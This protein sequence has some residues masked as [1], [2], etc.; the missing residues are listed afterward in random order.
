MR[1]K[2]SSNEYLRVK[3]GGMGH[4]PV[5]DNILVQSQGQIKKSLMIENQI[6]QARA[7]AQEKHANAQA[8]V[9]SQ[10]N[11]TQELFRQSDKNG[12]YERVVN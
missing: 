10:K 1:D 8:F 2:E 4:I 11:K 6:D 9:K 12:I 5:K 3:Y 7:E